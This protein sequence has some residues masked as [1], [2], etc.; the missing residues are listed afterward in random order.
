MELLHWRSIVVSAG[1]VS[2]LTELRTPF[3]RR[4][5]AAKAGR[6]LRN[7]NYEL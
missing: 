6:A 4:G 3:T 2:S 7:A 1:A 5:E